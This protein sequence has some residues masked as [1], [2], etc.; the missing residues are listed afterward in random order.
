[1]THE[2]GD[3]RAEDELLGHRGTQDH[4]RV[5]VPGKIL[6]QGSDGCHADSAGDEGDLG[7]P[8]RMSREGPVRALDG[9]AGSGPEQLATAEE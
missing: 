6:E 5:A 2:L 8:T 9:D 4:D 3:L 1:M 7:P